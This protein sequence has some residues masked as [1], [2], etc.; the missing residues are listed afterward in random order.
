M[1]RA[2]TKSRIS[3]GWG[4]SPWLLIFEPIHTG[5]AFFFF[6]PMISLLDPE[7]RLFVV[8]KYTR[9]G[10]EEYF[11]ESLVRGTYDQ[12]AAHVRLMIFHLNPAIDSD[13][14]FDSQLTTKDCA[15]FESFGRS[16]SIRAEELDRLEDLDIRTLRIT[17]DDILSIRNS[18]RG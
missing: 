13:W 6:S 10:G 14:R 2:T 3:P 7:I 4:D 18:Y 5:S 16:V 1:T 17:L 8:R 15:E 11:E 9:H 12:L